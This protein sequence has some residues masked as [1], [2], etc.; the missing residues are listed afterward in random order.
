MTRLR[1]LLLKRRLHV[2]AVFSVIAHWIYAVLFV[3]GAVSG[4][5]MAWGLRCAALFSGFALISSVAYIMLRKRGV[6]PVMC[7]FIIE[8][9]VLSV[10]VTLFFKNTMGVEYLFIALVPMLFLLIADTCKSARFFASAVAFAI[11]ISVFLLVYRSVFSAEPA[12]PV[13]V[14]CR[15][16]RAGYISMSCI[17]LLYGCCVL[18][19]LLSLNKKKIEQRTRKIAYDADHDTLTGLMNRRRTYEVL[20]MLQD[21]KDMQGADFAIAIFDIDNFKH[22]NEK[23]GHD[24]GDFALKEFSSRVLSALPE[25]HTKVGRWGGEEFIIIYMYY[26]KNIPFALD[27]LRK[28]VTSRPLVYNGQSLT[29]TATFGISSSAS[30]HNY[31]DVI[32]D[33]DRN[34]LQGKAHGKDRIK[35]SN[36]F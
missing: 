10:A 3:A 18:A 31:E 30:I 36:S 32:V 9:G 28:R 22:F 2:T 5:D 27:E 26:D 11:C 15:W 17:A 20:N 14:Y 21:M 29:V 6:I 24:C 23:Y 35:I 19:F 33:A 4:E 7:F 34:L 13:I 1:F 8:L 25:E 16:T 12:R